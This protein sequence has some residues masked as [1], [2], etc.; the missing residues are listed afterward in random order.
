MQDAV[1][2]GTIPGA[3]ISV[4]HHGETILEEGFAPQRADGV[5]HIASCAKTL[6]AT[7]VAIL[8]DEGRLS[9][10]DPVSRWI[11]GIAGAT[12]RHLL[13]HSAGLFANEGRNSLQSDLLRNSRLTLRESVLGIAAQPLAY[14]PGEGTAYSDAGLMVAGRIAEI[15]AGQEFDEVMRTRLLDPLGMSDTFYRTDRNLSERM[16]ITFHRSGGGW[17]RAALQPRL[18]PDGLIKVGGGLFSTARDLARF[19]R[20]HLDSP[21]LGLEM[22]RDQTGGRW[23]K[24]PMGGENA[25][26]GL[27]WQ[28]GEIAENGAARVFFHAGAFGTLMWADAEAQ[29]GAVLLTQAPIMNVY[30]F[31]RELV[32]F[33][34]RAAQS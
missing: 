14:T 6:A 34:R 16:A 3:A 13:S 8:I 7:T 17:Q 19:L 18:H 33:I 20:F 25:G 2:Q 4:L 11:P 32:A 1:E 9:L 12:V 28:L 22:R 29:L 21:P 30:G 27:G 23:K 26:Y 10:D 24:D 31:W 15:V 5:F